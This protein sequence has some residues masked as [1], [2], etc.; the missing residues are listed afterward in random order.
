M[1]SD[2]K[3]TSGYLGGRVVERDRKGELKEIQR[4]FKSNAYVH[5]LDQGCQMFFF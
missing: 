1:N 2:R 4:N 3:K 5:Y